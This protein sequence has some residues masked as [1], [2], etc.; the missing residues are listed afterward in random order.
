MS[1]LC[2]DATQVLSIKL[3]GSGSM[4][5]MRDVKG[6]EIDRKVK[7]SRKIGNYSLVT[8]PGI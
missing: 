6:V 7:K 2:V 1:H 3:Q 5:E 4:R 8:G